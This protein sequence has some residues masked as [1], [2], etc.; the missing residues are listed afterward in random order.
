[1]DP[2]MSYI[3]MDVNPI[4][5]RAAKTLWSFGPSECK[6]VNAGKSLTIE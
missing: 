6:R 2:G 3:F 5:L 1:M 4:A